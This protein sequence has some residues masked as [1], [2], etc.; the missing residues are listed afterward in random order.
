MHIL[1]LAVVP[2]GKWN[3]FWQGF[4]SSTSKHW[5]PLGKE[6]SHALP[7]PL[8]HL[9]G[10]NDLSHAYKIKSYLKSKQKFQH[11]QRTYLK[12]EMLLTS[13]MKSGQPSKPLHSNCT[14][15]GCESKATPF[16]METTAECVS[17]KLIPFFNT[18]LLFPY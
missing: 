12:C 3:P 10:S 6:G 18:Q 2:P 1:S 7:H 11:A 15:I 17:P 13:Q 9:T 8:K 5:A 4:H 14:S 16:S